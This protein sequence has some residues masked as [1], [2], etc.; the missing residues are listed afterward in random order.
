MD[1]ARGVQPR[2]LGGADGPMLRI[3]R[4]PDAVGRGQVDCRRRTCLRVGRHTDQ[5]RCHRTAETVW[6][7]FTSTNHLSEDR[8]EDYGKFHAGLAR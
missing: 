1:R 3:L 8:A 4:M 2:H 6:A 5:F 7:E